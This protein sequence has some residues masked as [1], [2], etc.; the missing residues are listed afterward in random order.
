MV[1]GEYEECSLTVTN[2]NTVPRPVLKRV[3]RSH[4]AEQLF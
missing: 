3:D 1:P 4:K 2:L